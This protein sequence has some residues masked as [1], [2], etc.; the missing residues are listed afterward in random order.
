MLLNNFPSFSLELPIPTVSAPFLSLCRIVLFPSIDDNIHHF[1][2]GSLSSLIIM[3]SSLGIVIEVV[4]FEKSWK[5]PE[6]IL[7]V[8][9]ILLNVWCFSG[10]KIGFNILN[11]V[12]FLRCLQFL[13]PLEGARQ[14]IVFFCWATS[15]FMLIASGAVG[16][17]EDV[18]STGI[19]CAEIIQFQINGCIFGSSCK[20]ERCLIAVCCETICKHSRITSTGSLHKKLLFHKKLVIRYNLLKEAIFFHIQSSLEYCQSIF[21]RSRNNNKYNILCLRY[22]FQSMKV[23]FQVQ[24]GLTPL[25]LYFKCQTGL[26]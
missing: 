10:W 15:E 11:P 13:L 22:C 7:H 5:M 1:F 21:V 12:P 2:S 4:K 18:L 17:L 20:M 9:L 23:Y 6:E 14:L 26:T 3:K 24:Q 25:H 16:S 8:F 19:Y